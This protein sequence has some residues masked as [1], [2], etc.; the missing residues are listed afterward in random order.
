MSL[1]FTF[2]VAYDSAGSLWL[3]Y[4]TERLL[5]QR[6]VMLSSSAAIGGMNESQHDT[7]LS[8]LMG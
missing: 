7:T 1:L 3:R 4:G 5:S 6:I 2:C 8:M